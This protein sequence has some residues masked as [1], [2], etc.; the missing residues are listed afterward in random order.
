MSKQ[1]SGDEG[2]ALIEVVEVVEVVVQMKFD[3]DAEELSEELVAFFALLTAHHTCINTVLHMEPTLLCLF[4]IRMKEVGE[5]KV[6][7]Q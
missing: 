7:W 5:N 2:T 4:S 3:D 1:Q 6:T